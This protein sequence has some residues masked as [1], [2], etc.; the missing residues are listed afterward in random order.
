MEGPRL[1]PDQAPLG[2]HSRGA[3]SA[4]AVLNPLVRLPAEDRSKQIDEAQD[5]APTVVDLADLVEAG[6]QTDV[7]TAVDSLTRRVS[8]PYEDYIGRVA[9]NEVAR[10]VKVADLR[11]NLA[12]NQRRPEAPG[13]AERIDRYEAALV[14][15]AASTR[16]DGGARPTPGRE[17]RGR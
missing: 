15:L 2:S 14:R 4:T 13:N 16:N 6:Y 1:D 3:D 11:E 10:R 7:V 9:Q 17:R 8:E 5:R 12:N